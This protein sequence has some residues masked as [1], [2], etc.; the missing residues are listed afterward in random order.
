M[1]HRAV[2]GGLV[3]E[4]Q[5][6]ADGRAVYRLHDDR[7]VQVSE[8]PTRE[9]GL[10]I[11]YTDITELKQVERLRREQALAQKTRLLQRT[12]DSLSQG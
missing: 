6:G 2:S 8:R 5:A 3:L 9:G 4:E 1:R 12:V 11:L 10:V 7:W